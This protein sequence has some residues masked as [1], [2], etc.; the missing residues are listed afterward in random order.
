M[1]KKNILKDAVEFINQNSLLGK[2]DVFHYAVLSFTF[3]Q[4]LCIKYAGIYDVTLE[5]LVLAVGDG[6]AF[7]YRPKNPYVFYSCFTNYRE[8]LLQLTGCTFDHQNNKQNPEKDWEHI[9]KGID[10]G[11]LI[12]INGPEE[13]II[14][15][16]EDADKIDDRKLY[17][18]SR[19][20]PNLNGVVSWQ[21]FKEFVR[22]NGNGVQF[23][24]EQETSLRLAPQEIIKQ[25]FPVIAD[26]QE[27]HP[28]ESKYF[29]LKALNQFILDLSN[30]SLS[31]EY[32]NVYACHPFFYQ[33]A[34][35]YWQGRF[36][37]SLADKVD[38]A[39]IKNKLSVAGKAYNN[40]SEEMQKFRLYNIWKGWVNQKKREK[41]VKHLEAAYV[42]EKLAIDIIKEITTIN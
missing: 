20:G 26:W 23:F 2:V 24:M 6:Y 29:G 33:E 1:K 8:R 11:N 21:T 40:I 16:Y 18:I 14:Y 37:T 4:Y 34:A 3:C 28:G 39:I 10:S 42:Q 22:K 9:V 13:G 32:N 41:I 27:N 25:I 36:F 31:S 12:Q 35:R 30:P 17:F 7:S 15:G 38:N 5:D 19:W